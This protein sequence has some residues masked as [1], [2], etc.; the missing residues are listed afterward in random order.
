LSK[1]ALLSLAFAMASFFD[2]ADFGHD[3]DDFAMLM[4]AMLPEE[5]PPA[6]DEDVVEPKG[7][8]EQRNEVEQQKDVVE[9]KGVVEQRNEVG[10]QKDVVEQKNA[11]GQQEVVQQTGVE[12][13][14]EAVEQKEVV[15]QTNEVDQTE[16]ERQKEAVE[17]EEGL[18]K[19][20]V[21]PKEVLTE[22]APRT[23]KI[24]MEVDAAADTSDVAC[25]ASLL[26]VAA[27]MEVDSTAERVLPS[28][29]TYGEAA[30]VERVLPSVETYEAA[31]VETFIEAYGEALLASAPPSAAPATEAPPPW[32]AHQESRKVSE[33]AAR[34]LAPETPPPVHFV[35]PLPT[36]V[37]SHDAVL[38]FM[39]AFQILVSLDVPCVQR[40]EV[41]R[42]VDSAKY[43]M[44]DVADF[45]SSCLKAVVAESG[46]TEQNLASIGVPLSL[47]T[48]P[49]LP[50]YDAQWYLSGIYP[51]GV[52]PRESMTPQEAKACVLASELHI[53]SSE[54]PTQEGLRRVLLTMPPW[55]LLKSWLADQRSSSSKSSEGLFMGV[56]GKEAVMVLG[57]KEV[58]PGMLKLMCAAHRDYVE[59]LVISCQIT[60]LEWDVLLQQRLHLEAGKLNERWFVEKENLLVGAG[61]VRSFRLL[62]A[63]SKRP[64]LYPDVHKELQEARLRAKA[65]CHFFEQPAA[66][67]WAPRGR[68]SKGDRCQPYGRY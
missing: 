36:E 41:A 13:R 3:V 55:Y 49:A 15:Q 35:M 38:S 29:E 27:G 11:V 57:Q 45:Y 61:L 37:A 43:G 28:V 68:F 59:T 33:E 67:S 31:S 64:D 56:R 39:H 63:K 16:V 17:P 1:P 48:F 58:D 20:A 9:L 34:G 10:Q 6:L 52:Q 18:P 50:N 23:V 62:F 54:E 4:Q 66:A 42:L 21:E 51:H 65:P 7:A 47:P 26:D 14:E 24:E 8:V 5:S 25:V 40:L 32:R 2:E 19:N 44:V 53:G 46:L 60:A 22:A 30:S 12:R